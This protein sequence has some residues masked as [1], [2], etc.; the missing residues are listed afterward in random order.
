MPHPMLTVGIPC[1]KFGICKDIE[2]FET[3]C[4]KASEFLVLFLALFAAAALVA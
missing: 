1:F 2:S 3:S 4:M